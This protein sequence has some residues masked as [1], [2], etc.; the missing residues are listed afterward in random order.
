MTVGVNK[1]VVADLDVRVQDGSHVATSFLNFFV[2]L[3]KICGREIL[4]IEAEVLITIGLAIVVGPLDIHDE[5]VDGELVVREV[6]VSL[7]D[8]FS[9]CFVIL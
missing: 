5:D 2:H 6:S 3:S 7:H 1:V 8:D 9:G 4:R